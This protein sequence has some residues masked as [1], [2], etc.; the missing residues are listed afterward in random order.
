MMSDSLKSLLDDQDLLEDDK[1]LSITVDG[2]LV[3]VLSI[4][5]VGNVFEVVANQNLS[6]VNFFLTKKQ[7]WIRLNEFDTTVC[8]VPKNLEID[9]RTDTTMTLSFEIVS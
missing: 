6:V 3:R 2:C 5:K 4:T 1:S 8:V 9:T 7:G